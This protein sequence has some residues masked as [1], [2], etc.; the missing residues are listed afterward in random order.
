[1]NHFMKTHRVG[2]YYASIGMIV[3]SLVA[4]FINSKMFDYITKSGHFDLVDEIL[5][6]ILL[7]VGV[8]AGYMFVRY[9]RNH[10]EF[11]EDAEN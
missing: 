3:G 11:E 6:P 2:T 7:I 8:T 1:M 5:G 10:P 4:V 9:V